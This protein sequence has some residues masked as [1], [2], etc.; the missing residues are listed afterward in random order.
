MT[1]SKKIDSAENMIVS[2]KV[3][4]NL[5]SVTERRIRQL[6]EEG[7]VIRIKKGKYAL[8]KSVQNYIY[9]LKIEKDGSIVETETKLDIERE[10]ALYKKA[11]REL[12]E[13]DLQLKRNEVHLSQ[14]VEKVMNDMLSNFRGK[15]LNLAPKISPQLV[16][17]GLVETQ[18]IIKA[19][20][21]EALEEL[22]NYN[23]MMFY[24]D[25]MI[26]GDGESE[27]DK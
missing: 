17:K 14:D 16:G 15:L 1:E 7:I 11:K 27:E 5:F 20:V 8:M 2:S 25:E 4:A 13:I 9:S 19:N 22:S 3:L 12:A 26:E 21:I 6:T 18:D 23:P 24:N 10:D